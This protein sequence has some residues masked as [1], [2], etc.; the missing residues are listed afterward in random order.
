MN[1]SG[2]TN[3]RRGPRRRN[4]DEVIAALEGQIADLR[5]RQVEQD[6]KGDPVLREIPRIQRRLRKFAQVAMDHQ[7]ADIAN[8]VTAFVAGL[9]RILSSDG[10]PARRRA[11]PVE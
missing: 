4:A 1:T 7:R 3:S 9:E 10:A 2:T 5:S 8:S 6:R 11:A